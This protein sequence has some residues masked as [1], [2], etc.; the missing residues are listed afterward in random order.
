MLPS[1]P[2]IS[3]DPQPEPCSTAGGFFA[4][5]A[6]CYASALPPPFNDCQPPTVQNAHAHSIGLH[7]LGHAPGDAARPQVLPLVQAWCHLG[8]HIVVEASPQPYPLPQP[9]VALPGPASLPV[10][11]P[12]LLVLPS[13]RRL[14]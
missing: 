4:L 9:T 12:P 5:G 14:V 10:P 2:L 13:L 3:L 6:F 7:I 8:T 1:C 11:A